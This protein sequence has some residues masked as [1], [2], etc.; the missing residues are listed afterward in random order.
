MICPDCHTHPLI[1]RS[2]KSL[3]RRAEGVSKDDERDPRRT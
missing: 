2:P 3:A 1:L